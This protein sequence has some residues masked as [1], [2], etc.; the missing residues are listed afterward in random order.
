M[1]PLRPLACVRLRPSDALPNFGPMAH[2]HTNLE[3]ETLLAAAEVAL[4]NAGEQWT[5]MRF[6]VYRA[7]IALNKPASAYEIADFIAKQ[8]NRRVPAN[9]VYRILDVFVI[10]NLVRRVESA[11]AYVVNA[12][13]EC[14]HDC[15][16]LICDACGSVTHV[17]DDKLARQFRNLARFSGFDPVRP[18]IEM[19]GRCAACG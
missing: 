2:S 16:F 19:H 9:S 11:N 17:D 13:P 5:E 7:L 6:K 10:T 8:D 12:H 4:G 1:G 15:V 18:V 14:R 3:G